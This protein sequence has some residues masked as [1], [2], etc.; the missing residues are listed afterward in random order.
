MG[1]YR[2]L[3]VWNASRQ[4]ATRIYLASAN[5]PTR[6][7]YE[8][9]SQMR[10]AAISVVSNIAEGS[11]R[12]GNHEFARFLRIARGS[13]TE[14]EAQLVMAGDLKALE[15]GSVGALIK[16]TERVRR[17]LSGLLRKLSDGRRQIPIH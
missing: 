15:A 6:D 1:D 2:K 4:L 12:A 16:E 11:G 5:M 3:D 9:A 17:M 7:R 8:L 13:A 10:R 14:L